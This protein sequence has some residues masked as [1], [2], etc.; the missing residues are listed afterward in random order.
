M[1]EAWMFSGMSRK[2]VWVCQFFFLAREL[3][4]KHMASAAAA[5]TAS[6]YCKGKQFSW[7]LSTGG[8]GLWSERGG[9]RVPEAPTKITKTWRLRWFFRCAPALSRFE[10]CLF[11][12]LTLIISSFCFSQSV[13]FWLACVFPCLHWE[14]RCSLWGCR[15]GFRRQI[16]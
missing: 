15:V 9:R 1:V 4:C 12:R 16:L 3:V 10:S 13:V 14:F 2:R 11:G 6:F 7:L 5:V 8:S